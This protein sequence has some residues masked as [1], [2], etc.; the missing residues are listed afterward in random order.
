M[1]NVAL[2]LCVVLLIAGCGLGELQ[3]R[4]NVLQTLMATNASLSAVEAQIGH[5]PIYR[6]DSKG[7]SDF[8][9]VYSR[10][11]DSKSK[12]ILQK[13]EKSSSVGFTSTI[14]MQTYIF[15]DEQDK[16]NDFEVDAQ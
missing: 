6:R 8:R 10:Y 14:S 16:L 12:R 2:T 4:Q 7:W 15:L 3:E 9:A 11:A 1:R 5:I 13:I